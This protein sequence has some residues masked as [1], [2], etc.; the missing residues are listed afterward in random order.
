V[1][2]PLVL[3]G[4]WTLS[5]VAPLGL[6]F[7]TAWAALGFYDLPASWYLRALEWGARA[8]GGLA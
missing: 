7:V 4:G 3:G 1:L 8:L 6:I 5:V 2:A